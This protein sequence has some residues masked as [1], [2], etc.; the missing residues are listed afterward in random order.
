[1]SQLYIKCQGYLVKIKSYIFL[2]L[3]EVLTDLSLFIFSKL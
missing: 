2:F 3:E 1:M